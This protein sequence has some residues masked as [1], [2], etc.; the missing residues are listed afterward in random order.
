MNKLNSSKKKLVFFTAVLAIWS[1]PTHTQ[2]SGKL[3]K[4]SWEEITNGSY[5]SDE[6][7]NES[8]P[9]AKEARKNNNRE[10]S[11]DTSDSRIE[12]YE[13]E[14]KPKITVDQNSTSSYVL[15]GI[16]LTILISII[17]YSLSQSAG[18]KVVRTANFSEGDLKEIEENPFENDLEL[19]IHEALQSNN[20]KLA[21]RLQFIY[22][23]RLLSEKGFINW[24]KHKTNSA[25]AKELIKNDFSSNYKSLYVMF[26]HVW[27]G[28]KEV[29]SHDLSQMN[30]MF[31]D[32]VSHLKNLK[33][34]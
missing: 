30:G 14:T 1:N 23:I 5:Y 21:I 9:P 13:Y 8:E 31:T 10:L 34:K 27:Y 15:V 28:D 32:S 29:S 11:D 19:M 3:D 2:N 24:K 20:L 25:Y 17:I 26:E 4:S 33:Q 22:I 6:V 16:V 18:N 7:R 12:S